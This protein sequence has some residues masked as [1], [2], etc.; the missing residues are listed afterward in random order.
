MWDPG[1]LAEMRNR[2]D[3]GE[4]FAEETWR[5]AFQVIP[6][7]PY[8]FSYRFEDDTGRSSEM[9]IL[10]WEAGAL[11]WSCLRRSEGTETVAL[12]KVRRAELG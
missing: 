6:K 12:A 2:A 7:L 5:K 8:S 4:M 9:Q 11:Y 3:Q 10:D 1:K